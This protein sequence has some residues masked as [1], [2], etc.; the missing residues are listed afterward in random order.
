MAKTII[1]GA[2]GQIG[3]ELVLALRKKE[4]VENVIAADL[5]ETCPAIIENG[6]YVQM[7][8]LNRQLV[9]SYIIQNEIK[10]VYLLAAL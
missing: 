3:T 1:I 10:T 5:K 2:G 8:I 6:P 9:R 4:G 7:D